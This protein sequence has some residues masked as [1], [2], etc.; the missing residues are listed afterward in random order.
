MRLHKS[1]PYFSGFAKQLRKEGKISLK[2]GQIEIDKKI[3]S[4]ISRNCRKSKYGQDELLESRCRL[5]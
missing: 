4:S 5:T 2:S 1:K 3:Q